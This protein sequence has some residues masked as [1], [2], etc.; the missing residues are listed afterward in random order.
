MVLFIGQH[1]HSSSG[2]WGM[3]RE[4]YYI[5]CPFHLLTDSG[6]VAWNVH[7]SE[8][9]ERLKKVHVVLFFQ[10][11]C[12]KWK[13][14]FYLFNGHL[15][16]LLPA[17]TDTPFR[18]MDLICANDTHDSRTKFTICGF[19]FPFANR[20]PTSLSGHVNGKCPTL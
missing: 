13:F 11:K 19:C 10:T 18:Y 14:A 8:A 1:A 6:L 20:K 12:S 5:Q 9:T 7:L 3:W 4:R 16:Y 17:F 2:G 15:E